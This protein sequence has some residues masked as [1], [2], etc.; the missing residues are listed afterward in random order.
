MENDQEVPQ[1]Q[2][3]PSK[4]KGT[5]LL[6][7]TPDGNFQLHCTAKVI[8]SCHGSIE[9]P[10]H[11][12]ILLDVTCLHPQGGGQPCDY[13]TI[14][15]E[16]FHVSV[17]KVL[18][19]PETRIVTHYG[20]LQKGTLVDIMDS[21]TVQVMVDPVRRSIL[22]QCHSAGH[23]IDAAIAICYP[24]LVATKGYHY[25]DGPYVVR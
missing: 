20:I 12:Q 8:S 15:N 11:V 22:S 24:S 6:H 3:Q 23:A 10:Q 21:S 13:G 4:G 25:L 7:Y 14:G 5:T 18:L 17:H 16:K 19:D 9:E 1:P 2:G